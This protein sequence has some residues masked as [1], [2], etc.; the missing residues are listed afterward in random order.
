MSEA[1][2]QG[3]EQTWAREFAFPQIQQEI[4][5]GQV[6]AAFRLALEAERVLPDDPA[7]K[8]LWKQVATTTTIDSDPPGARVAIR[9]WRAAGGD[10]LE[11]AGRPF[12]IAG[13]P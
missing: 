11:W 6:V 1:A 5:A 10:W 9:D 3:R 13:C 7:L 2:R 4:Q 8:D 12:A